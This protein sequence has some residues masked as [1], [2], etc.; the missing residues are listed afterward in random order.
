MIIKVGISHL[1]KNPIQSYVSASFTHLGAEFVVPFFLSLSISRPQVVNSFK[2]E[3]III[4]VKTLLCFFKWWC[5]HPIPHLNKKGDIW[6]LFHDNLR[7][8]VKESKRT[9]ARGK[10]NHKFCALEA[11]YLKALHLGWKGRVRLRFFVCT[12]KEG[13]FLMRLK[14]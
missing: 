7:A 8:R 12:T 2:S 10:S 6:W 1:F 4:W 9:R 13:F 5:F 3:N 11:P 14:L